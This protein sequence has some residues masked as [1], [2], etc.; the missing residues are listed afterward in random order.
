MSLKPSLE[1][2]SFHLKCNNSKRV[3]RGEVIL[4]LSLQIQDKTL[5]MNYTKIHLRIH[6]KFFVLQVGVAHSKRWQNN[7]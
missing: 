1:N 3:V 2:S 5:P 4:E 7:I 6:G